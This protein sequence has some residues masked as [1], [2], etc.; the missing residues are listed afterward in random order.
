MSWQGAVCQQ[1]NMYDVF[2]F[3]HFRG[4]LFNAFA[5]KGAQRD[6]VHRRL[7]HDDIT[8]LR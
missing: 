5:D 1:N 2:C 3:Y 8:T 6:H 4:F 7:Y